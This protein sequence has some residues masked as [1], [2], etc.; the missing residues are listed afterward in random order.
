MPVCG[1]I[2]FNGDDVVGIVTTSTHSLKFD[3]GIGY[4]HFVVAGTLDDRC[5]LIKSADEALHEC[6]IVTLPSITGTNDLLEQPYSTLTF[7]IIA[8]A[9]E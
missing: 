6:R 7:D 3:A 1:S 9:E 2:V 5:L 8:T 4:V